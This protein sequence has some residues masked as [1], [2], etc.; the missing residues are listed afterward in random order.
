MRF[1]TEYVCPG[2]EARDQAFP[3]GFV[4]QD[5]SGIVLRATGIDLARAAGV[6]GLPVS[7]L[8]RWEADARSR[9]MD[10]VWGPDG[11]PLPQ[12]DPRWLSRFAGG[13]QEAKFFW[14]PVREVPGSGPEVVEAIV[15]LL[16]EESIA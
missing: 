13:S 1:A 12:T 16:L 9:T 14:G 5:Q 3:V 6:C 15:R 11:K 7:A 4:A 10:P 8:S 2:W